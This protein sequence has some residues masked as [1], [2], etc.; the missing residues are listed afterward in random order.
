MAQTK[1]GSFVESL[2]NIFV[3]GSIN[4]V[5]TLLILPV[6]WN[7]ASPKL[8]SLYLTV[9][10]TGISMVRSYCLRR[11]FNGLRWGQAEPKA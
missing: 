11:W 7:P 1:F 9:F 8:S 5:A 4:W 6:L 10:Y 2:V 3:G